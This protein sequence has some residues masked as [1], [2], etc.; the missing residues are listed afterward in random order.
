V[1]SAAAQASDRRI[2]WARPGSG[3]DRIVRWAM[4]VLPS[5][6]GALSA[7]LV[8]A[9]LLARSEIS[10]V[11]AK[12]KVAKAPERMRVTEARYRGQD[13]KGRPFSISAGG[14]LQQTS[15]V[16]VVMLSALAGQ[17]TLDDGLAEIRAPRANYDID[18]EY[19]GVDGPLVFRSA[20]GYRLDTSNVGIDMKSRRMMSTSPVTGQT[21]LGTFSAARLR[22]DLDARTVTLDGQARLHIVQS[23]TRGQ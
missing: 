5:G 2:G 3:H 7:V 23:G 19:V 18:R 6:I 21:R 8:I 17:M 4:I 15:K 12:D 13:D 22:A 11:L 14:A 9:P 20:D 10:F 16:P 1:E